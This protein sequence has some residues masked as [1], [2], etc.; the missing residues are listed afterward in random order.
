MYNKFFTLSLLR[1][2]WLPLK[3]DRERWDRG[4]IYIEKE[5]QTREKKEEQRPGFLKETG[6]FNHLKK[7][8]GGNS[9]H[10]AWEPKALGAGRRKPDLWGGRLLSEPGA[11]GAWP[12]LW[13]AV[14]RPQLSFP[15]LFISHALWFSFLWA[16]QE[17]PEERD[18]WR[19][20]EK[21]EWEWGRGKKQEGGHRAQPGP[22]S[23]QLWNPSV[24][25][26]GVKGMRGRKK[27]K[28]AREGAG[29]VNPP[30]EC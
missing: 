7:N 30:S 12:P 10:I 4:E 22:S 1:Q 17:L 29:P 20:A 23:Q 24:S 27:K 18:C 28:E 9:S 5:R 21:R 14:S 16:T 11:S 26:A 13:R 3:T 8:N 19:E 25:S 15:I 6:K 2:P